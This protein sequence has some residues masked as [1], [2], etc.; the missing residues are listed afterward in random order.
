MFAALVTCAQKLEQEWL[1]ELKK[2][3]WIPF[4]TGVNSNNP[5]IYNGVNSTD[6]YWVQDGARP[7]IMNLAEYIEDARLV[8]NRRTSKGI[9]TQLEIRFIQRNV[10]AQFA[11]EKCVIKYTSTTPG[12][13]PEIF[14]GMAHIF[15]RKENGVWKKLIQHAFTEEVT[16]DMFEA[17]QPL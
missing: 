12:K 10:T 4:V 13:E 9:G 1:A 17:A 3:I 8:M 6:F 16:Q 7:R 5:D 11:S 15:S 14:Y 2:D